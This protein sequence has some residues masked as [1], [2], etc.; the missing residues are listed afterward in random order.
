MWVVT[1]DCVTCPPEIPRFNTSR[2]TSFTS[3]TSRVNLSY[4]S[5]SAEGLVV[6]DTVSMGS[7][8]VAQQSFGMSLILFHLLGLIFPCVVA[9][10][11]GMISTSNTSMITAPVSGFMGLGFERISDTKATPFLQVLLRENKLTMPVMSF[12][13][14]RNNASSTSEEPGG[15][16][17]LGGMNQNLYSGEIEYVPLVSADDPGYWSIALSSALC[18]NAEPL[19]MVLKSVLAGLTVNGK[20][21]ET[22][23]GNRSHVAFETG[24]ALIGMDGSTVR[25][26]KSR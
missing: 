22:S 12:F 18:T 20:T 4:V 23:T 9:A 25:R 6:Q 11:T 1:A 3:G 5:G 8:S 2:S 24:T 14:T 7:L 21:I 19:I 13:F 16:F 26:R 15:T 17:T 10:V